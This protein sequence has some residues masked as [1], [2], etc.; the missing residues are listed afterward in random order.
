MGQGGTPK[1]DVLAEEAESAESAWRIAAEAAVMVFEGMGLRGLSRDASNSLH[2]LMTAILSEGPAWAVR[3]VLQ[4]AGMEPPT[5]A[6]QEGIPTLTV[7]GS[8]NNASASN[9]RYNGYTT[10]SP[11]ISFCW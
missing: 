4:A 8:D 10:H 9:M 2:T 6:T 7:G 5:P 3:A 11:S 1:E